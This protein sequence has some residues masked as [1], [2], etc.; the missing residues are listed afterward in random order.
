ML[1]KIVIHRF[2]DDRSHFTPTPVELPCKVN[3]HIYLYIT[4]TPTYERNLKSQSRT[5]KHPIDSDPLTFPVYHR[6]R[7]TSISFA[8]RKPAPRNY[9][10][11]RPAISTSVT[12]K[13]INVFF[14]IIICAQPEKTC[15]KDVK[16]KTKIKKKSADD[17]TVHRHSLWLFLQSG[18]VQETDAVSDKQKLIVRYRLGVFTIDKRTHSTP[19]SC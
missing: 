7:D 9:E 10:G 16:N 12:R 2:V 11:R 5:R 6:V 4:H 1:N 8:N 3:R 19:M 14:P 17:Q 13:L 15:L 18:P